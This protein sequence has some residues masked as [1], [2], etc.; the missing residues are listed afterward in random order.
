MTSL[1]CGHLFG[2]SCIKRWVQECPP[3]Q[4]SCPTCKKKTNTRDFRF[5]YAK[6]I[7]VQDNTEIDRLKHELKIAHEK[8]KKLECDLTLSTLTVKLEKIKNAELLERIKKL[9]SLE[10]TVRSIGSALNETNPSSYK[11]YRINLEKNIDL[12]RDAG[13]RVMAFSSRLSSML[14]SQKSNQP[15]FPGFRIRFIDL[16]SYRVS[17]CLQISTGSIRDITIEEENNLLIA[18]S[19]E[20]TVKIYN[21]NSKSLISTITLPTE[22]Q[23]WACKFDQ[24]RKTNVYLGTNKGKT[25]LYD[26]RNPNTIVKEY[27]TPSD[28]SPVIN[29]A[30]I[31]S[32]NELPFGG[33]LVCKLMSLRFFELISNDETVPC[34]L[35]VQGPFFSM[36]HDEITNQIVVSCRPSSSNPSVRYIVGTL[37]RNSGGI[38]YFNTRVTIKGSNS[39]QMMIR[40]ALSCMPQDQVLLSSYLEDSKL[41]TVWNAENGDKIQSI[42]INK[43]LYDIVPFKYNNYYYC[44]GVTESDVKVFK[45][46][47]I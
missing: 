25:Y 9:E 19:R 39:M 21:L 46:N 2:N 47:E 13:C 11:L 43:I 40:S 15:L 6:K 36:S 42:S 23:I 24:S 10:N 37:A 22:D 1:K 45:F 18:A 31:S 44:G 7:T 41:L 14:V 26:A 34:K 3:H 30:S 27:E 17:S 35:S 29:I 4:K 28:F 38:I 16:P 8:Y 20:K 12:G 33:F 5:I 32:S